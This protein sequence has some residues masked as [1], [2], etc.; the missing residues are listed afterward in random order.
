MLDNAVPRYA[1]PLAFGTDSISTQMLRN[2]SYPRAVKHHQAFCL[3]F[4]KTCAAL[5]QSPLTYQQG[6]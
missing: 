2:L 3:L 6:L 5:T 4:L 1:Y